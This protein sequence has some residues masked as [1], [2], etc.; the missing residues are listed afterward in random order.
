MLEFPILRE[1]IANSV[2]DIQQNFTLGF[3]CLLLYNLLNMGDIIYKD[4][5]FSLFKLNWSLGTIPICTILRNLHNNEHKNIVLN[6]QVLNTL[7]AVIRGELLR[8]LV[9]IKLF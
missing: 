4:M 7:F 9:N 8:Y 3:S 2:K 5:I 6:D 1:Q